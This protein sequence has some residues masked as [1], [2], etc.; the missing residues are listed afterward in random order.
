MDPPTDRQLKCRYALAVIGVLVGLSVAVIF[1]I[2]FHNPHTAAWG[3]ASGKLNVAHLRTVDRNLEKE[4]DEEEQ[5]VKV[6]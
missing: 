5:M 6:N 1:A 2:V 4:Q 3:L